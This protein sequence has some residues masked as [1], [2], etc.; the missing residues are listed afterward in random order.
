[1][2]FRDRTVVCSFS[3][4]LNIL[5]VPLSNTKAF[6]SPCCISPRDM[7]S[8]VFYPTQRLSSKK[9]N[10]PRDKNLV[11][12]PATHFS[13]IT[14][15]RK[16]ALGPPSTSRYLHCA[17]S[18]HTVSRVCNTREHTGAPW[19]PGRAQRVAPAPGKVPGGSFFGKVEVS[20]YNFRICLLHSIRSAFTE[21]R[22]LSSGGS[23]KTQTG[24]SNQQ[25]SISH[26]SGS[27]EFKVKMQDLR[28][29]LR[30]LPVEDP[31]LTVLSHSRRKSS[32]VASSSPKGTALLNWGPTLMTLL[33][34]SHCFTGLASSTFT[35]G[36]NLQMWRRHRCSVPNAQHGHFSPRLL[37]HPPTQPP[38][39][40]PPP[41]S[42]REF[43]KTQL[44]L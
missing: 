42:R 15:L 5:H 4:K 3:P 8:L 30:A 35:W 21:D 23:S 27:W 13:S 19:V 10:R 1:M 32:A 31:F 37:Q 16:T 44:Q 9:R 22:G 2:H 33:N 7:V 41:S 14:T 17:V 12:I 11:N 24:W 36:F 25:T 18:P 20:T 43:P 26:H 39:L 29:L 34:L 40:C 6:P 38:C 28:F